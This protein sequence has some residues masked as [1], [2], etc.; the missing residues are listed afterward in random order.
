M[1]SK[2]AIVI[3]DVPFIAFRSVLNVDGK[4]NLGQLEANDNSY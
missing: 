2:G 4:K 3:I 1:H